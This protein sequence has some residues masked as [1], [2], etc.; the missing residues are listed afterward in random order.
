MLAGLYAQRQSADGTF[1]T[2]NANTLLVEQGVK[3]SN[4]S[5][6][7]KGNADAKRAFRVA[8]RNWKVSKAGEE[9]LGSLGIRL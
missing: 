7:M 5:Q 8:K 1:T 4:A 3:L 6:A 9:H 2:G